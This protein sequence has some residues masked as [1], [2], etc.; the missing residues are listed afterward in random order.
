MQNILGLQQKAKCRQCFDKTHITGKGSQTNC[1]FKEIFR[2]LCFCF[3]GNFSQF[4]THNV[5]H[6]WKAWEQENLMVQSKKCLRL[7]FGVKNFVTTLAA[8]SALQLIPCLQQVSS[9]CITIFPSLNYTSCST[10]VCQVHAC[11]IEFQA[12]LHFNIYTFWLSL[13][14]TGGVPWVHF[15][16]PPQKWG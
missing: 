2:N 10:A 8:E 11:Q 9:R 3:V 6:V 16:L 13:A 1:I 4:W 7:P 5:I 12:I 15:W 14:F